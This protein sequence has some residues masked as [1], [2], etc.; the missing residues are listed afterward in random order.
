MT[1][2]FGCENVT[3]AGRQ[4]LGYERA[5]EQVYGQAELAAKIL[6]A[7]RDAGKDLDALSQDDLGSFD[8]L[9]DGERESTNRLAR[10]AGLREGMH[11]LDVGSGLGGPARRLASEYGCRVT[12]LDLR[13]PNSLRCDYI[14]PQLFGGATRTRAAPPGA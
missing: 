9:H 3:W 10:L 11:V 14:E 12:G 1:P 5:I 13:F 7:L 6:A 8:E 4:T 2:A